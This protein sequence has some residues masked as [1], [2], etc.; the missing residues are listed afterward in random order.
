MKIILIALLMFLTSTA[1]AV[2]NDEIGG[3]TSAVIQESG[4]SGDANITVDFLMDRAML[5]VLYNTTNPD[6]SLSEIGKDAYL[7]G[8]AVEKVLK[9]YPEIKIRPSIRINPNF[10]ISAQ[11]I[12]AWLD[13]SMPW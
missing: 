8:L 11:S 2:T 5:L 3:F 7:L 6:P 9:H 13:M 1:T 10:N 4:A 12:K